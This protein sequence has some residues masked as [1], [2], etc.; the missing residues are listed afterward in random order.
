MSASTS[1]FAFRSDLRYDVGVLAYVA[2]AT[3]RKQQ[4]RCKRC[5]LA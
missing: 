4:T 1:V 2:I 3:Y 5:R